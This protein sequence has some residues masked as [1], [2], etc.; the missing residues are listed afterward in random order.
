MTPRQ[1]RHEETGFIETSA[2][3]SVR[4]RVRGDGPPLLMIHGIG[5]PLE[6][7]GPLEEE[8]ADFQTITVD[9]PGV[10]ESSTP[11]GRFGMRDF[12]GVMDDLL[13]HLE[14]DSASVLGLS[15]GGMMAQE[16]ARRSPGRVEKLVLCSTTCG[17]GGLPVP[18]K[19][20]AAIVNPARLYS[21]K[22]YLK[23]A[24]LMYGEQIRDDP[25]LLE[26]H[27]AI[28]RDA[29]PSLRGHFVQLRAA[30]TW[31]SLPWLR[32]LDMPVLVIAGSDD[33]L[34]PLTNAR[35]LASLVR[36]GRL[37]VIEGGSHLC[38]IQEAPRIAAI[39]RDFLEEA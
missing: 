24:P 39:I 20:W 19:T 12:A 34:I 29:K 4:Y 9:A 38:A 6:F 23:V 7:W 13:A 11:P 37:E 32:S 15:L 18:P 36:D 1:T 31:S 10:G 35:L 8:L 17:L 3:G 28:R 33:R 2:G 30:A 21:R 16:L 14:L 27:M 5:A 22:H 26:Q 25:T